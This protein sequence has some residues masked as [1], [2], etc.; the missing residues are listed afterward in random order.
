MDSETKTSR[1][2]PSS[3][4]SWMCGQAAL[5][6]R[7]GIPLGEGL[8]MVA[9]STSD[10][11]AA[12]TLQ[13]LAVGVSERSSLSATMKTVGGFPPYAVDMVK[14]GEYT[15]NLDKVLEN[16]SDYFEKDDR[17][18]KRLRGALMYPA[19]LLAMM[20]AIILMLVVEV[21]P[22]FRDILTSLG[23]ELP[24]FSVFLLDGGA[25]LVK[26]A[27]V[28]L[29][30]LVLICIA[31]YLYFHLDATRRS[32]DAFK[33]RTPFFRGFY[34]RLHASRF[35]LAMGYLLGSGCGL[36]EALHL[37][38][39]VVGN[40]VVAARIE[41]CRKLVSEGGD[42]FKAIGET[43]IFPP[44]FVHMLELGNR[45]G[46]LDSVM[47]R[48]SRLYE[49]EVDASLRRITGIVEPLLVTI[50]SLVVGAILLSVMLPL[51]GIMSSIG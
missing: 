18:R 44:L 3:D 45:T 31:L 10:R 28:F 7:A 46:E 16:L 4:L 27:V 24:G 9:A 43:G 35:S 19:V 5:V 21:L 34:R 12:A 25:F 39:S 20:A 1:L 29:P 47:R 49:E 22:V 11:R 32:S 23:G 36:E 50:L 38:S 30:L 42:P 8:T 33:L 37:S 40:E 41:G 14:V 51:I 13:R 6:L 2:L 15:G 26:Y 17:I 48:V